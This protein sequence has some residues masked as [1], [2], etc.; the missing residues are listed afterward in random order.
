MCG[1]GVKYRLNAVWYTAGV[2]DCFDLDWQCLWV[3]A[4]GSSL[5]RLYLCT[6]D[7]L[8]QT[9]NR[10][11]HHILFCLACIR[12][13]GFNRFRV[14]YL[15]QICCIDG[16]RLL[17]AEVLHVWVYDSGLLCCAGGHRLLCLHS[18]GLRCSD[19]RSFLCTDIRRVRR[20]EL[21]KLYCADIVFLHLL[22]NLRCAE[23]C[24]PRCAHQCQLRYAYLRLVCCV[25]GLRLLLLWPQH[26]SLVS[27]VLLYVRHSDLG[28]ALFRLPTC[29]PRCEGYGKTVIRGEG[30]EYCE[31]VDGVRGCQWGDCVGL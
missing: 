12:C 8:A 20:A 5:C 16:I 28:G 3:G 30:R 1:K 22:D 24:L 10:I 11:L 29:L 9:C 23:S 14:D 2:W 17:W 31:L 15:H 27:C 21:C 19:G 7:L 25:D 26:W 13:V 4:T 6:D 18:R